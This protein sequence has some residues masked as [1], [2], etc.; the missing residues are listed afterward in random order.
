M[1]K[2]IQGRTRCPRSG[3]ALVGVLGD[4][5]PAARGGVLEQLLSLVL[6]GLL[7]GAHAQVEG[8]SHQGSPSPVSALID[9]HFIYLIRR[10]FFARIV[11]K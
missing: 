10:D 6:D 4:D 7:I 8:N 3:D 1:E 5:L 9:W 11:E 2:P